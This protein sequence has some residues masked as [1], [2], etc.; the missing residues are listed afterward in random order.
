MDKEYNRA[1]LEELA[2]KYKNGTIT[3]DE[4]AYYDTWYRHF[5]EEQVVLPEGSDHPEKIRARMLVQIQKHVRKSRPSQLIRYRT[6]L[7]AASLVLACT[8]VGYLYFRHRGEPQPRAA[9]INNRILPGTN[10]AILTLADGKRIVLEQTRTGALSLQGNAIISKENDSLLVYQKGRQATAAITYN[11]L[12]TPEGR[13]YQ[14]QLPDGSRVWLNAAS[15]LRYPTSFTEKTRTVALSGEAYFEVAHNVAMPFIVKSAGQEVKVLG[16]HFNIN[17]YGD[18]AAS[19]TTL[20]Q[21]SVQV[22]HDHLVKLLKPGQQAS[23][24]VSN[25]LIADADT[26]QATAWKDGRI[27][28]DH[29]DIRQVLR[30]VSRWY[31][32][33]IRY[34]G[35]V[36]VYSLSGE[37][38]R[39]EDLSAVLKMLRLSD[40]HFEQQGRKLIIKD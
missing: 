39:K 37:V 6:L 38:S 29:T 1:Y 26:R 33:E 32:I 10:G 27:V 40:V 28:F 14:V 17:A 4:Q 13:Q 12:E 19:V 16:T 15:S 24:S 9:Q 34:E 21:G 18:E 30:E 35:R 20:L 5:N 31:D 8:L 25:I 7:T 2:N 11:T 23:T 22:S 36:P 3:A